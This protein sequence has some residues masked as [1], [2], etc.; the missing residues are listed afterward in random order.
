MACSDEEQARKD[1]ARVVLE[2]R[3]FLESLADPLT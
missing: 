3:P 2:D 1:R